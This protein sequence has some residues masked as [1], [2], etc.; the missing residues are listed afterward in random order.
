MSI[1][2]R[3]V[4][5][6]K[7]DETSRLYLVDTGDLAKMVYANDD[8]IVMF[9]VNINGN[10]TEVASYKITPLCM[11]DRVSGAMLDINEEN[12]TDN[13]HETILNRAFEFISA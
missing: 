6:V 13:L 1:R 11:Q 12:Y 4:V 10:Y 2:M 7:K 9:D 3:R 8:R 5:A